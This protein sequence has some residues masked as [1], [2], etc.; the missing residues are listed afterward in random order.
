MNEPTF[1]PGRDYPDREIWLA[2][3]CTDLKAIRDRGRV[4]YSGKK[5]MFLGINKVKRE[6]RSRPFGRPRKKAGVQFSLIAARHN[7]YAQRHEAL[8]GEKS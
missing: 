3:R 8:Q 4:I 7:Y 5:P 1:F 2:K 6:E